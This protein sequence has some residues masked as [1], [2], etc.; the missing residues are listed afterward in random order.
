MK[1]LISSI[2]SFLAKRY[3]LKT[4]P[5]IIGV[6]G[7]VGKTS[8]KALVAGLLS[9]KY[10]VAYSKKGYNADFGI[11][12]AVLDQ[13]HPQNLKNVWGWMKVIASSVGTVMFSKKVDYLVL[14]M[15]VDHPGEMSSMLQFVQPNQV[16]L[17]AISPEHM[18]YFNNLDTVAK[19]ELLP[20]DHAQMGFLNN[21]MVDSKYSRSIVTKFKSIRLSTKSVKNEL[22]WEVVERQNSQT[23]V[24]VKYKEKS[25]VLTVPTISTALIQ[26]VMLSVLVALENEVGIQRIQSFLPTL[27]PVAGR[28]NV[29]AGK[30]DATIIDDTYNS[31]PSALVQSILDTKSVKGS[32]KILVLGGMNEMGDYAPQAYKTVNAVIDQKIS[33]LVLVGKEAGKYFK[34]SS[35]K[36]VVKKEKNALDAGMYVSSLL[37]KNDVV[38]LKGSQG[39]LFL[40][41]TVK[42]LLQDKA[43]SQK[44]CRQE[45]FWRVRK[46]KFFKTKL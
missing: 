25:Y 45:E 29:F 41:E 22:S 24:S 26:S 34:S 13:V 30:Q 38:L 15:G 44:L 32:R 10:S 16:V 43:D 42:L 39:G 17:T 3:L 20:F 6:V 35:S 37:E 21:D 12:L 14:E 23:T 40:E 31:S 7:S 1:R 18:E 19:E 46:E 8:V 33:H 9:T 11:Y 36:T 2:L 28:M 4:K 27:T 5:I